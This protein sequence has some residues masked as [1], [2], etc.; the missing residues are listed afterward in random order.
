MAGG[1][2]PLA[3]CQKC[4]RYFVEKDGELR[5]VAVSFGEQ[6]AATREGR[7]QNFVCGEVDCAEHA[8][9]RL[10][11][12]RAVAKRYVQALAVRKDRREGRET[13]RAAKAE[14]RDVASSRDTSAREY[15]MPYPVERDNLTAETSVTL[16]PIE[17]NIGTNV[18]SQI[19]QALTRKNEPMVARAGA[20]PAELEADFQARG[21]A[22]S[23]N[24]VLLKFFREPKNFMK[25]F[26]S[27]ELE[28]LTRAAGHESSRMNNRAIWLREQFLA[29]GLYLDN[30]PNGA[31][32]GN[33]KGSWYRLCP[34]EDATSLSEEQ[35]RKLIERVNNEL[36]HD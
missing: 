18:G 29:Q 4:W 35:K 13:C 30:D 5:L 16:D 20:A 25:A 27:T 7:V 10:E 12:E 19:E 11:R 1:G 22:D 8:A 6:A 9:R 36:K 24:A 34:I 32:W 21:A 3:L 17:K 26:R 28:A 15:R 14:Q 33:G 23:A 31:T 2:S